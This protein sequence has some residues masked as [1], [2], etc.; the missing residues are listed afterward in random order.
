MVGRSLGTANFTPELSYPVQLVYESASE[1]T[2]IFGYAWRSPQL[3]SSAA[4]DKDGVLWTTPWGEKIKFRPKKEKLQKDA[5]RV[6]LYEEAK[7]GRGWYAPYSDWETDTAASQPAK[8]GDW[9]F[10]GKRAHVGWVLAYRYGYLDK[11]LSVTEG[12][13][14]RTFTYYADGQLATATR[15]GGPRS[16]A[17]GTGRAASPPAAE[18]ETFL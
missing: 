17:A 15:T 3:E 2:G 11:V 7:K 9:T 16:V 12:K 8:T 1:R 5:V 10:T 18:T 6:A 13:E 14:R 4:W